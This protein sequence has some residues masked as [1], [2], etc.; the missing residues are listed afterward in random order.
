MKPSETGYLHTYW[1]SS[2]GDSAIRSSKCSCVTR[3]SG[4]HHS[5]RA[6]S[7]LA[8]S[9]RR[10]AWYLFSSH[11]MHADDPIGIADVALGSPWHV[12]HDQ[13]DG[14]VGA[15]SQ[16]QAGLG[17]LS[18]RPHLTP[19]L[20]RSAATVKSFRDDTR[21]SPITLPESQRGRPETS[22]GGPKAARTM[23]RIACCD[24]CSS[25]KSASDSASSSSDSRCSNSSREGCGG[26]SSFSR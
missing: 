13:L 22:T 19:R 26:A 11:P 9:A 24:Y 23:F 7:H 20:L 1:I 8:C 4:S 21:R 17:V 5:F 12:L 25:S 14:R 6:G 10:S 15:R 16:G 2:P 3:C 18:L